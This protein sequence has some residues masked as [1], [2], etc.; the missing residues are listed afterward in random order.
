MLLQNYLNYIHGL[1]QNI[2]HEYIFTAARSRIKVNK[3]FVLG[4]LQHS[5]VAQMIAQSQI[6]NRTSVAVKIL[7]AGFRA[8]MWLPT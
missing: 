4:Q 8:K 1:L 7:P 6:S 2:I 3:T 5:I